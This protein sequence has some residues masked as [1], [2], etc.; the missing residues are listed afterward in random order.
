MRK[1]WIKEAFRSP[2]FLFLLVFATWYQSK[3]RF[4]IFF[5]LSF[6]SSPWPIWIPTLSPHLFWLHSSWQEITCLLESFNDDCLSLKNKLGFIDGSIW[7]S[8]GTNMN[9]PSSWIRN[10]N[11]VIS[12]IWNSM[13]K[14]ISASIIFLELA[15]EIRLDLKD[16]SNKVMDHAFFWYVVN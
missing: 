14:D 9:L 16:A 1:I 3:H 5:Y 8:T 7:R 10:S 4:L 2:P 12:W 6:L 11:V 15:S 13:S